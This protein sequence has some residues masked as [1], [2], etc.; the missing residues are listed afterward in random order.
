MN[1]PNSALAYF[2]PAPAP[3]GHHIIVEGRYGT[4]A[5]TKH[6]NDLVR[7]HDSYESAKDYYQSLGWQV[8]E[9]VDQFTKYGR[10]FEAVR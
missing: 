10:K 3:S 1:M 6:T 5:N 7:W 4:V 2:I 9:I 8:T